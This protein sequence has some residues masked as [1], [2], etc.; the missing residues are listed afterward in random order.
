MC[1]QKKK[2]MDAFASSP[3][4]G[5]LLS[6]LC[7]PLTSKTSGSTSFFMPAPSDLSSHSHAEFKPPLLPDLPIIRRPSSQPLLG[8]YSRD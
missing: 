7:T 8:S 1:S 5:V 2:P 3:Q 6:S 4:S